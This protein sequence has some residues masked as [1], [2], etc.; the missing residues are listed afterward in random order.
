MGTPAWINLAVKELSKVLNFD[1]KDP[2]YNY[3]ENYNILTLETEDYYI[4]KNKEIAKKFAISEIKTRIKT[5][6]LKLDENYLNKF[7]KVKLEIINEFVNFEANR[8]WLNASEKQILKEYEKIT[9][10]SKDE[11]YVEDC[12]SELIQIYKTEILNQLK[13]NPREYFKTES[14][15]DICNKNIIIFEVEK[16]AI[17]YVEKNGVECLANDKVEILLPSKFVVYKI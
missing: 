12:K 11:S 9:N 7:L 6:I 16:I 17:D 1:F 10:I 5:G 13:T 15:E 14:F 3:D 8:I 4:F 2:N